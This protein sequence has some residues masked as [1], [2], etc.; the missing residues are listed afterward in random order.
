MKLNGDDVLVPDVWQG[1][2][3]LSFLRDKLGL[4]GTKVWLRKG[5]VRCVYGPCGWCGNASVYHP[6]ERA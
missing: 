2:T 5:D 3:L 1:E 4:V 6:S